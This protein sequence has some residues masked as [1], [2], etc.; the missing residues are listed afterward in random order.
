MQQGNIGITSENIFP[1]IKKFLYSDSDIFI[2]EIIS[3]AVDAIKKLQVVSQNPFTPLIQVHIDTNLN[4][5]TVKDNGIGMDADEI[6]KYIN[7]IAFSGASDFLAKYKDAQIIGHFGLGFYSSF[8]VSDKVEIITKSYKENAV[9]QHWTCE[10]TPSFTLE[11][12]EKETVGTDIVMHINEQ[13]KEYLDSKKIIELLNTYNKFTGIKI[14]VSIDD[15][16]AEEIEAIEPLWTKKPSE[17]TDDDYL[18]FYRKLYPEKS[19]PLYW[20]HLNVD[21][22]FNLSGILYFP[23][24]K[25]ISVIDKSNICLYC[26]QVYVTDNVN[27]I[28][29]Q[30]LALLRGVIDSPDIPLN[31]SRS[32]LQ[33]DMN[34]KKISKYITNKVV[35]ALKDKFASNREEYD[36]NWNDV[37]PFLQVGLI[38]E[39]ELYDKLKDIFLLKDYNKKLY[40]IEEYTE[41]TKGNQTDKDGNIVWLFTFDPVKQYSYITQAEANG[42][43]VLLLDNQFSTYLINLFEHKIEKLKIYRVDSNTIDKL[44][45]KGDEDTEKLDNNDVRLLIDIFSSQL[46]S[47]DNV[48]FNIRISTS[49]NSNALPITI[50]ADEQSRRMRELSMTNPMFSF[51]RDF[52]Q[53]MSIVFDANSD[54]IKKLLEDAKKNI[55][56]EYQEMQDKVKS[57]KDNLDLLEQSNK[58]KK[59]EEITDIDKDAEKQYKD[60]IGKINAEISNL[61]LSYSNNVPAVKQMLDVAYLQNGMLEKDDLVDFIKRTIGFIKI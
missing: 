16:D 6:E 41:L 30:F 53:Q 28:L 40:T 27:N 20:L 8:M 47:N 55:G 1:I 23:S 59:P 43:S 54:V 50:I 3:N 15:K 49:S 17:L 48:N 52:K 14:E 45:N 34:V 44:I 38:T 60:G 61:V 2:R 56:K 58:N 36:K 13:Y 29:P 57:Y 31:V 37:E 10:G 51:Y 39:E 5:I 33:S 25:E 22:P 46:K 4:T 11:D 12:T 21:F 24:I 26:N 18:E 32:Y 42:Y 9:P 19:D 35:N 7:Q